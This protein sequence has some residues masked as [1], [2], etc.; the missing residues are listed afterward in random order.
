MDWESIII[1]INLLPQCRLM[2]LAFVLTAPHFTVLITA[3]PKLWNKIQIW[4][5]LLFYRRHTLSISERVKLKS[6]IGRK[7]SPKA[8]RGH[9]YPTDKRGIISFKVKLATVLV[10][11]II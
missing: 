11:P 5:L 7:V 9:F 3:I 4:N 6:S 1:R 10:Y 8:S 2:I